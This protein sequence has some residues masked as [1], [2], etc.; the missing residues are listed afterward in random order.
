MG[1]EP[2]PQAILI[3]GANGAGKTTFARQYL[4][5]RYPDMQFLNA[6]E[7]QRESDRF[8]HPFAAGRELIL[9][10]G[11]LEVARRSFAVESTLS[12]RM[13][14][15]RLHSWQKRGMVISSF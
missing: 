2:P 9:R 11:Q 5:V 10:L 4:H 14:L 13:Y 3:S 6:D 7:I 1:A 8:R 12:S 15:P